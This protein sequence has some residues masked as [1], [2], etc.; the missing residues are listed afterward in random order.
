DE[1]SA[2]K[3]A[4]KDSS[5]YLWLRH[6][7]DS[8]TIGDVGEEF[9]ENTK[10]ELFQDQVFC[11]TPK[12]RLIALPRGAIPVDFAYAVHTDVGNSCMGAKI[13]GRV[14][15]L[16][17][18]LEN[19]DE[20]EIL[21]SETASPPAAWEALV[22]TGKARAAI[23]RATRAA[24]RRQYAGLGH[25]ILER[26]FERAGK[27]FSRE[28]LAQGVKRL[29][30]QEVDDALAAVGRGEVPPINVIKAVHPDIEAEQKLAESQTQWLDH[31]W[32]N[33]STTHGLVFRFPEDAMV[34]GS[35]IRGDMDS[36]HTPDRTE[37]MRGTGGEI[38]V[39]FTSS[40]AVPGDRI[41]GIAAP[42]RGITIYPI[43]S[44]ALSQFDNEPDRWIDVRWDI[45]QQ[46][47]LR[48]PAQIIVTALN[49]PGSLATIATI[50][51]DHDAN[52]HT[53]A[54][55]QTAPDFTE[56]IFD[57]EVWDLKHLSRLLQVL[58][59]SDAVSS[60]TRVNN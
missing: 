26:A 55:V 17:T 1:G 27:P 37:S 41:V 45:D 32:F 23:R 21:T 38:A 58:Q 53:L 56:M 10:L 2:S 44:D 50:I 6:T 4:F 51:A 43:H 29:A 15:P 18:K 33:V 52:I 34:N 5:A 24:V 7:I 25:R 11:F 60:A 36:D 47:R 28:L 16:V 49:E 46:N 59:S 57:L 20:V 40:G 12:G 42:G 39:R 48:F 14:M 54:M 35:S 9:L 30:M 22:A 13:N 31:G 19:G 3:A 8:L